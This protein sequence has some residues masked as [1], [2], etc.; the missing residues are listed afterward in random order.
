MVKFLTLVFFVIVS[1]E[2]QT[3]H[4]KY[5]GH[6]QNGDYY[7]YFTPDSS[8]NKGDTLWGKP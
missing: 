3:N 2:K 5:I 8:L 7:T 6:D 4:Y 1:K